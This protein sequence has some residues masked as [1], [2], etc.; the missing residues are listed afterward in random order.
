MTLPK[1]PDFTLPA[2]A[3]QELQG[4]YAGDDLLLGSDAFPFADD[5]SHALKPA[6]AGAVFPRCH[7]QVVQTV[8]WANRHR[9]ALVPSGGRTGL[10]GG[11]CAG[12]GELV[13]S[14]VR[15]NRILSFDAIGGQVTA[16]AGVILQNLQDYVAGRGWLYP[17]D[18]ASRGS[19]Q[20]GGAAATNAGGI[21]VLRYGMTRDWVAG[22]KAVTGS[23]QTL[24]INRCIPKDNA[25]YDLRHL[26][27]GSEGT[28]AIIT[29]VTLQLT[30]PMPAQQTML[31]GM[32]SMEAMLE[33][34]SRLRQAVVLNAAEFFCSG[35]LWHV[36]E[37][38][39]LRKPFERSYA[40]YLLLEFD[41]SAVALESL[42]GSL[43]GHAVIVA[44]SD[45]Q[46]R[47]LWRYRE[48]I[49]STLNPLHPFKYDIA[50]TMSRLPDWF[51]DLEQMFAHVD[52]RLRHVWFGHL[53]DGN[54]HLNI[55]AEPEMPADVV[56]RV[57]NRCIGEL[58]EITRKH[59]ATMSAEHG[60]GALKVGWLST[61]RSGE[62]L[63]LYRQIRELFDP[64]GILNPGKLW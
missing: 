59:G 19:A 27:L 9:V 21:R 12:N 24:D 33:V 8:Q 23:G 57:I 30:H 34:F 16:E 20:I 36:M 4:I 31:I 6:P 62:E 3:L 64:H 54:L 35:A 40:Y 32:D 37:R 11:A 26:L 46:A 44:G 7:E 48:L 5:E 47:Q 43:E 52:P 41:H 55:L 49:S 2:D 22:L 28:L 60:I 63:A 17:V 29:A 58:G 42:A 10:S 25:G 13:V 15:M 45:E 61:S 14:M 18:Y 53:G 38:H 56:S 1:L 51:A 50:C 39:H